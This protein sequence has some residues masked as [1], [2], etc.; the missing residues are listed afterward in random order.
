MK[1]RACCI[2]ALLLLAVNGIAEAASAAK[3]QTLARGVL[4]VGTYF[5]NP[6][7]EYLSNGRKIGF[8]VDLMNEI[9]RRLRLRPLF[10]DT[11]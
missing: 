3:V 4:R 11:Q 9:A 6:P 10:V 8:E 2:A 7:F 1:A 5:F